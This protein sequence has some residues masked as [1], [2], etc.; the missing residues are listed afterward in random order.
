MITQVKE[1]ISVGM[2]LL[3]INL[4]SFDINILSDN[5]CGTS[6]KTLIRHSYCLLMQYYRKR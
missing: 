1:I 6:M 4:C 3:E 2:Y 5:Y